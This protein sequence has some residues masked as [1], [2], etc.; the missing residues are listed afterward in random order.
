MLL[1]ERSEKYFRETREK[2]IGECV[3]VLL[4]ICIWSASDRVRGLCVE[5][6]PQGFCVEKVELTRLSRYDT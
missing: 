1:N 3:P 6:R 5:K 2:K 4:A